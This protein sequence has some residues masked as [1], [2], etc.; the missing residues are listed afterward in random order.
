MIATVQQIGYEKPVRLVLT[1]E[2]AAV[3]SRLFLR[4]DQI[5]FFNL[6][7][8]DPYASLK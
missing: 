5:N 3:V 7:F 8:S 2:T 1:S 6:N 4:M